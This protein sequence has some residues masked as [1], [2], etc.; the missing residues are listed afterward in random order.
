MPDTVET[1]LDSIIAKAVETKI[2][3]AL[4]SALAGDEIL[5]KYVT[6]ALQ[7]PIEVGGNYNKTKT[8]FL[9]NLIDETLRAAV[10]VACQKYIAEQSAVLEAAVAKEL[11]AQSGRIAGQLVGGLAEKSKTAYGL[12]IDVK[13][14]RDSG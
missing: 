5:G 14:P 2:E 1:G 10:K 13:F 9:K 3:A 7:Q 8:T 11:R 4:I 12:T 6:A